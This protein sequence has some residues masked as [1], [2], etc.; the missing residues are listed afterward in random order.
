[1]AYLVQ[2]FFAHM[3]VPMMAA[4]VTSYRH[5]YGRYPSDWAVLGY[6]AVQVLQQGAAKA[7]TIDTQE[8]RKSLKG[9]TVETTRGKLI[10]RKID[11]QLSCSVYFGR[12]ADDPNY[13][14]PIYHDLVEIKAPRNWRPDQEIHRLRT[15]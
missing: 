2:P 9:M 10:F 14:F 4:F 3:D 11:N 15:N 7:G 8:I 12:V 5:R 6:D 1:M 13:P